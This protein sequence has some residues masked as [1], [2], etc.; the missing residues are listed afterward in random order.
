[1]GYKGNLVSN[2]NI[3]ALLVQYVWNISKGTQ[4]SESEID[5]PVFIRQFYSPFKT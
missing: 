2:S 4:L 5:R 3:F 1:M